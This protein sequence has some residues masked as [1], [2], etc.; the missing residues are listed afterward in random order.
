[1]TEKQLDVIRACL[2]GSVETGLDEGGVRVFSQPIITKNGFIKLLEIMDLDYLNAITVNF[3]VVQI[4]S[5]EGG[6]IHSC[7]GGFKEVLPILKEYLLDIYKDP[8]VDDY[9]TC[10]K[11]CNEAFNLLV[12]K[13]NKK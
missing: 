7:A 13:T 2:P 9:D 3:R 4:D 11:R 12:K 10:F 8:K 5:L 1:M 6:S